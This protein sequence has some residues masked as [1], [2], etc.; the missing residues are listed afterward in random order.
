[1]VTAYV[2]DI[3]RSSHDTASIIDLVRKIYTKSATFLS[4]IKF[5][6]LALILIP[7]LIV[8]SIPVGFILLS[9]MK[10]S[11]IRLRLALKKEIK[12]SFDTY[13]NAKKI[14]SSLIE[15]IKVIKEVIDLLDNKSVL[16]ATIFINNI[17][18]THKMLYDFQQKLD[19]SLTVLS[20]EQVDGQYFKVIPEDIIWKNRVKAYQYRL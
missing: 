14:Q 1:M 17:K 13:A 12:I 9:L 2:M 19:N 4:K 7:V 15:D 5:A 18:D 8:I 16:F 6:L 3:P 10:I 11:K 20:K